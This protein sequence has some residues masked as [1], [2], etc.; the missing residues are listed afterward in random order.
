MTPIKDYAWKDRQWIIH[1]PDAPVQMYKNLIKQGYS[2]YAAEQLSGY[3]TMDAFDRHFKIITRIVLVA[4]ALALF[5]AWNIAGAELMDKREKMKELT[6]L[7]NNVTWCMQGKP[8]KIGTE[9]FKC[10]CLSSDD[11]KGCPKE[12]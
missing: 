9:W 3:R 12:E 7:E 6:H 10:T 8:M 1:G 5:A 4:A 11:P 2:P